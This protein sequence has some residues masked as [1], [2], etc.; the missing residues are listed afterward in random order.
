MASLSTILSD[1]KFESFWGN[2]G[3]FSGLFLICLYALS[4][5][6]IGKFGKIKNGIWDLFFWQ[7]SS[8]ACSVSPTI[9]RMDVHSWK[10]GVKST[11]LD[12]FTSTL[13]NINN[14]I[15]LTWLSGNGSFMRLLC[16][17]EECAP[18]YL[19]LPCIVDQFFRYYHGTE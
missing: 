10:E 2:E 1:Y 6:M 19:V 7:E 12:S 14:L 8:R 18:E 11:Q 16:H 17:G 3:R 13:G 5:F 4:V 9:S 15:R